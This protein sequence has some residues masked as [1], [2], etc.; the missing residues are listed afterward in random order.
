MYTICR[1]NIDTTLLQYRMGCQN[2]GMRKANMH[3]SVPANGKAKH[4]GCSKI[5]VWLT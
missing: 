4:Y 2:H 3:I 5:T 1:N